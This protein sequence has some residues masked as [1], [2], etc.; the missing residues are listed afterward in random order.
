MCLG[1]PAKVIEISG[2]DSLMRTGKATC[3]GIVREIHLAGCPEARVGDYVIVH[4]GFAISRLDEVEA[5]H[6]FNYLREIAAD[7]EQDK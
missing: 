3:G 7:W 1:V 4:A 6:V 2:D 5:G